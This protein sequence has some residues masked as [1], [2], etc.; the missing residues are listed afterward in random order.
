MTA[1][2]STADVLAASNHAMLAQCDLCGKDQ[3][4]RGGCAV[5]HT[6]SVVHHASSFDMYRRLTRVF[7]SETAGDV[8]LAVGYCSAKDWKRHLRPIEATR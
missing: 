7:P 3:T 8:I 4:R 6:H 1:F 5:R 2:V